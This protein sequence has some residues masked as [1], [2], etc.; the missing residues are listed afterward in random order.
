MIREWRLPVRLAVLVTALMAPLPAGAEGALTV[1]AGPFANNHWEDFFL[2]PVGLDYEPAW[3][4]VLAPSWEVARPLPALSLEVEGQV[5]RY[6][7]DQQLWEVN[8]L[9]AARYRIAGR[10]ACLGTSVAFGLGPS[11]ASEQPPL[12]R[13][14]TDNGDTAQWL[15]YWYLEGTVGHRSWGPW[16]AVLR[17]HHRSGAFGLVAAEGGSNVPTLGVRRR[18]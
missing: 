9:V 5:G 13:Q 12:E 10:D 1:Y 7:G 11:W 3:L 4:A 6:F 2:D 8:A 15:V 18:F 14:I 16:S 17:L